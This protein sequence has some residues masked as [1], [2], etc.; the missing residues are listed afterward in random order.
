LAAPFRSSR[1]EWTAGAA[2]LRIGTRFVAAE[3]AGIY[4]TYVEAL[5]RTRAHDTVYTEA[6]WGGWPNAPRRV[7][8]A[9]VVAAE[10]FP[11]EIVGEHLSLDGT[12]T[13]WRRFECDV[14]T[15]G[16]TGAIEAMAHW[17]GESVNAVTRFQ[18]AAEIVRELAEEAE[19]LLRRW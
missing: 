10:A 12:R 7:L 15:R 19:A 1:R 14:A 5:I 18:P 2:G 13:P 6:F 16:V 3:E 9:S 8:R 17:D 11:G 4:P